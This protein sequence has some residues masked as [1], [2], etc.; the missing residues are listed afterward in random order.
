MGMM[1]QTTASSCPAVNAVPHIFTSLTE[2][3]HYI[4]DH[5]KSIFIKDKNEFP[6][7]FRVREF[8]S[9]V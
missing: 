5:F 8:I 2:D 6:Y 1:E 7:P 4:N 9:L 3:N